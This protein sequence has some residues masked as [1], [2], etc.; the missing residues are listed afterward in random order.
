[1]KVSHNWLKSYLDFDLTTEELSYW[2]TALGLEVEGVET[3]ESIKG[4]LRGILTGRVLTCDRHPNADKLSVTTVDVGLDH[5]LH[6]VC[7]APNV[8]VGQKV[9]VATVGTELYSADGE[10]WSINKSKIRGEV[11]EGMIC[12]E[13]EIGLG[14]SHEGIMVLPEDT[15]V[16]KK[17]SELFNIEV[18]TIYEIGL[19]PNRSDGTSQLGTARDL[20]A[21]L[22][23]H[24]KTK[25]KINYPQIKRET[26]GEMVDFSV[27]INNEKA[28]P[29]Y[30]GLVIQN[31]NVCE[32]PD[33]LRHR[34]ESVGVRPINNVVDITNFVLH[35]Y[36]QPMHAFDLTKIEGHGIVVDTL[37]A[38]TRFTT[39][40]QVERTLHEDD[41]MICDANKKPMCIAGVF[42]GMN[43]GVTDSTTSIFLESAHFDAEYIRRTSMR[44]ILRTDAAKVF[45]KGSDPN[46]ADEAMWRA[47]NLMK[48]LCGAK[49]ANP[50]FDHYP[51]PILKKTIEVRL[52][53][54]NE[55]IGVEFS[56]E[57]LS[58]LFHHLNFEIEQEGEE[59]FHVL[60]PT[61]KSDVLREVDVIEEILRIYGYDNVDV[62]SKL[63]TSL[64]HTI[65]LSKHELRNKLIAKFTARGFHQMMNLSLSRSAYYSDDRNDLVGVLNTSN[66]HLDIMRPDM[67]HSALEAAAHNI[68]YQNRNLQ[69]FEFGYCYSKVIDKYS[70]R[71]IISF[72]GSGMQTEPHWSTAQ[73]PSDFYAIKSMLELAFPINF[74]NSLTYEKRDVEHAEYGIVIC[75]GDKEIGK[76]VNVKP[77]FAKQ[78]DIDQ[79][80]TYAELDF[81]ICYKAWSKNE[82]TYQAVSKFP[83]VQRDLALIVDDAVT[84][85]DIRS[86]IKKSKIKKIQHQNLFDIYKNDEHIGPNKK[87]MGIRLHFIDDL[88]T[89]NDKEVDK[90][91]GK[92]VTSFQRDLNAVIRE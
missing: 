70:E 29:R 28:C 38:G 54:V 37:P 19:T 90:M 18:D 89:L 81:E 55:L 52:Q 36:G 79:P 68:K 45:E 14:Q 5:P 87:S 69:L 12:A 60:I 48:D 86:V 26:D 57:E 50:V 59:S 11:S 16:G 73:Q 72:V 88:K 15:S 43:A 85:G 17:A 82:V 25:I 30:A 24:L 21:G 74:L 9:L 56:K 71:E 63:K 62:S 13:D 84:Y 77:D 51:T 49:I 61:D 35:E 91:V 10:A 27:T 6:I 42:G 46:I 75:K 7:G 92:L 39:L 2:L 3:Y 78:F 20:A 44:H 83:G 34:L 53:K 23:Y 76:I 64:V 80:I 31:V 58:Q 22:G 66:S 40:D 47:A 32:S 33:W 65:G 1:M 8:A 41:L 67:L 4:G